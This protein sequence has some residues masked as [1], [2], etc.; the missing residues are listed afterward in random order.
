MGDVAGPS[1]YLLI[2]CVA[3]LL[4][5]CARAVEEQ[6]SVPGAS[7]VFE[8]QQRRLLC[9]GRSLRQEVEASVAEREPLMGGGR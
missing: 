2:M 4:A 9:G 7:G 8:P 3:M 1:G 5:D 6:L